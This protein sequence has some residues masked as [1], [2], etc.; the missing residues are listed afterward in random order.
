[1]K[2]RREFIRKGALCSTLLSSCGGLT[3]L[4]TN[5]CT[6]MVKENHKTMVEQKGTNQAFSKWDIS[7]DGDSPVLTLRNGEVSL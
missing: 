1:M 5:S 3:V 7:F 2:T 6:N 4:S